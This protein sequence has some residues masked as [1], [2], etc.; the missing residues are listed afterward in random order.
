V[1]YTTQTDVESYFAYSGGLIPSFHQFYWMG[2]TVAAYPNYNWMDTTVPPP[3]TKTYVHWSKGAPNQ[4]APCAGASYAGTWG[5]AW[6]WQDAPCSQSAPAICKANSEWECS[7]AV[8]SFIYCYIC[9][10]KK[11]V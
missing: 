9:P 3:S 5:G 6:G 1:P 10:A 8:Y 2:L 4:Q 11:P 7:A